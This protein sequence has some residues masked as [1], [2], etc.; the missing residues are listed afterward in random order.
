M[1]MNRRQFFASSTAAALMPSVR[2]ARAEVPVSRAL[3]IVFL[4][5]GMDALNFFAPADDR[6]YLAARPEPL[7]V[8]LTGEG[9]GL[10][11]GG[12]DG[13]G[14]FL[15]HP[16]AQGIHALFTSGKLALIPAAGLQNGTRSHFQAMD[17]VERGLSKDASHAPRDGWL[18]RA[19]LEIAAR[20]PGSIL[21]VGGAMPQSL[22]LC[23][24]ALPASDVWDIEWAPS[25]SF[26]D[27][28]L[29]MHGGQGSLDI[30]T[31]QALSATQHLSVKLAR[32]GKH[33]PIL[34]ELPKGI[35]YPDD[36]FGNKLRFLA[37]MMRISP[38]IG[39][40]TADLDGW[41]THDNQHDRFGEKVGTLAQSLNAFEKNLEAIGRPATV[42][43]MS[44][45]GRRVKAN[46]SRG[47]DHGHGGLMMVMGDGVAGGKNYGRWPGL[48]TEHL[49]EGA[50]LAVTTDFRDVLATVLRGHGANASISAA[51][52]G[53]EPN[54]IEGL[55]KA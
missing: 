42:V 52:P 6:D 16:K 3:V 45:F 13:A 2:W 33:E 14:D 4:R 15:L 40:A 53:Y 54:Y 24:S 46:E 7:R 44:E 8:K 30:A 35:V 12:L 19:A 48:A 50:D 5:G 23:E 27:A 17:L 38:D 34:R 25:Q 9:K 55:F 11:A 47:T 20:E 43:V 29:E 26:R 31:R 36:D 10:A 18:T 41:D 21:S 32:D 39:I 51:F 1:F 22:S 28:L 37:E 49:D